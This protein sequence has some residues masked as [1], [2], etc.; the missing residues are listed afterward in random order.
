M[1]RLFLLPQVFYPLGYS[2]SHIL[3]QPEM[4][5]LLW[6]TKSLCVNLTS[7]AIEI[8]DVKKMKSKPFPSLLWRNFCNSFQ[9]VQ[10]TSVP[11]TLLSGE[12]SLYWFSRQPIN[13]LVICD[14]FFW[15]GALAWAK[16]PATSQR[17]SQIE[18]PASLE[19][20]HTQVTIHMDGKRTSHIMQFDTV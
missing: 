6:E 1:S 4:C 2:N 8:Y 3:R 12:Q 18:R 9:N 15:P 14:F 7:F 19:A 5:N 10:Q 11:G 13:W 17:S 16:L 20:T